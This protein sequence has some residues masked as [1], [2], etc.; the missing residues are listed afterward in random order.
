MF[1]ADVLQKLKVRM[2]IASIVATAFSILAHSNTGDKIESYLSLRLNFTVR[3]KLKK[4]PKIDPRIKIFAIDDTTT[5][6]LSSHDLE[7]DVWQKVLSAIGASKPKAIII[8]KIFGL[9]SG[10]RDELTKQAKLIRKNAPVYAGAFTSPLAIP[11]RETYRYQVAR[12]NQLANYLP[13]DIDFEVNHLDW[14]KPEIFRAYAADPSVRGAFTGI[15]YINYLLD[16]YVDPLRR[17]GR[18]SVFPY[19]AF[20]PGETKIQE[21]GLISNGN[22]VEFDS[23]GRILVNMIP[24]LDLYQY[25]YQFEKPIRHAL[26]GKPIKKI[27]EGDYVIILPL[28]YTGHSDVFDTPAG[29]L[30]GGFILAAMIN[31]TLTGEWLTPV[32]Y[33]SLFIFAAT[34]ICVGLSF[35]SAW[36]MGTLFP[37]VFLPILIVS[38]GTLAFS[39]YG[40]LVP[41]L[42][43][44]VSCSLTGFILF[45]SNS[46]KNE[47]R[48]RQLK[49]A[50]GQAVPPGVLQ[51]IIKNPDSLQQK[52]TS[53]SITIVFIDMVGFSLTSEKQTPKQV[54]E[55]LKDFSKLARRII[56]DHSGVVDKT[57]G[58]GILCY[59]GH[60]F[61]SKDSTTGQGS[62][63]DQA[64]KCAIAIQRE[65]IDQCL[66]NAKRNRAVYPLRIGINTATVYIGNLGDENKIEFTI[67]GHGVNYAKRLEEGCELFKVLIGAATKDLLGELSHVSEELK[68]KLLTIK[69]HE[70]AR[71]AYEFDPFT[72]DTQ[73]LG[74]AL[75]SYQE[76]SGFEREKQRWTLARQGQIDVEFDIGAGRITSLSLDGMSFQSD[77]FFARG[78]EL[79]LNFSDKN[80]ELYKIVTESNFLPIVVEVRWGRQNGKSSYIHG[81][82]IKGLNQIQKESLLGCFKSQL[83]DSIE[84]DKPFTE[85][86]E[87]DKTI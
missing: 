59:F 43:P 64:L 10:D 5:A 55:D 47:I 82:R 24:M 87:S 41:W 60:S 6:F 21:N 63:A 27:K 15:G 84:L 86:E 11:K 73:I 40:F 35:L 18:D 32:G 71:E 61:V 81:L 67:V 75:R 62:H 76:Y 38:F 80:S 72:E 45:Y 1:T 9:V 57:L 17:T 36:S 7:F 49:Q 54:F 65:N 8:D 30:P 19:V 79:S 33:A 74:Q 48:T 46:K 37:I 70:D 16:G 13:K 29:S 53:H 28:M 39:Y 23:R 3:Q 56:H 31:S 20:M 77:Q 26:A 25:T 12:R 4:I 52:P 22:H 85:K 78:V 14:F 42:F 58:D 68:L 44:A 50:L 51:E 66:I 83:G 34:F 2:L 69:H